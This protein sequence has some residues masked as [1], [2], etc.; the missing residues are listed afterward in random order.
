MSYNQET[1]LPVMSEGKE[2]WRLYFTPANTKIKQAWVCV[3]ESTIVDAG[4]GI[5]AE[6]PMIGNCAIGVMNGKIIT[7]EEFE[8]THKAPM[9]SDKKFHTW[10]TKINDGYNDSV[11][12][13]NNSNQNVK[14]PHYLF[15]MHMANDFEYRDKSKSINRAIIRD[16]LMIETTSFIE[17][18]KE[19][20]I[21]YT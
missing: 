18:V 12:G 8:K 14:R 5:F 16:N 17:E 3:K 9:D 10:I 13:I 21:K 7:N 11:C 15:G 4:C 2:S 20:C 6:L 1:N 19:I